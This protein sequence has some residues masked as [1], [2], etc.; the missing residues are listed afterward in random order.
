MENRYWKSVK[1]IAADLVYEHLT[2]GLDWED[3]LTEAASDSEVAT[4][5]NSA[6]EALEESPHKD[7]WEELEDSVLPVLKEDG[8]EGL[9]T[10]MAVC[11]MEHDIRDAVEKL[12][13]AF[14]GYKE[15]RGL[16]SVENND[17]WR[18]LDALAKDAT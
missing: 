4:Y 2:E 12:L 17:L 3:V 11:A 9:V 6:V 1:N 7:A 18:L 16:K 14:E 15:E 8:L 10:F 5:Y 13:A